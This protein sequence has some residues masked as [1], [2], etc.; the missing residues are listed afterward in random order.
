MAGWLDNPVCSFL[1]VAV[2]RLFRSV[3]LLTIM[4]RRCTLALLNV[5]MTALASSWDTVLRTSYSQLVTDRIDPYN[6]SLVSLS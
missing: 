3:D 1:W 2:Q 4:A 6:S 5:A